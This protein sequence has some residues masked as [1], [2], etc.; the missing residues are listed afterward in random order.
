MSKGENMKPY[1]VI[2]GTNQAMETFEQ[3]V[4]AALEK[5][6]YLAGELVTHSSSPNEV[7]LFQPMALSDEEDDEDFDE[8]DE[9]EDEEEEE[10]ED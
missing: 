8:D 1:M 5:G 6:Y 10:D 2:E 9:D 7:K 4:A 3:K